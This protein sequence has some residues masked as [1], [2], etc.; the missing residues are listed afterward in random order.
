MS[1]K[2]RANRLYA[3]GTAG[4]LALLLTLT[5]AVWWFR[6]PLPDPT[7]LCP[8]TRPIAGHTVVIVDRTDRWA[9]EVGE[10]LTQLVETAQHNTQPYQ[11]F[12]IVA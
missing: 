11:K 10:A 7:T 1:D 5:L 9:P 2:A 4:V 3:G 8:T 12:S 6:P